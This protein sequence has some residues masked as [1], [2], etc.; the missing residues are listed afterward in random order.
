MQ[1]ITIFKVRY[2]A[3]GDTISVSYINAGRNKTLRIRPTN[4]GNILQDALQWL[5]SSKKVTI[6]GTTQD[7]DYYY[8]V[9]TFLS[10]ESFN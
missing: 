3:K 9:T 10:Y 1:N 4:S 6:I 5:S 7:F 2:N 8:V